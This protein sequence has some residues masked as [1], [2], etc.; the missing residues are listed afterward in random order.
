MTDIAQQTGAVAGE[1]HADWE[2]LVS[3][4]IPAYNHA[5][6][7]A[8]AVTSVLA[9]SYPHVELIVLDDGST[10]GTLGILEGFGQRFRWES[11][12]N[13]GQAATLAK[14]WAMARGEI[15]GYLS[16]DDVLLTDAVSAS[17][18][19][20]AAHP[21]ASAVYCDFRLIDPASKPVRE[22]HTPEF[23]LVRMAVELECPPGP[24]ALF[25][26][27]AYATAGPWN[28]AL[29]QMPDYDFWLRMALVGPLVRVPRVLAGFRVHEGSQTFG[30]VAAARAAEPVS[31]VSHFFES[32]GVPASVRALRGRALAN[33]AL[34]SAQLHVRSGRIGAGFRSAMSAFGR[35]P[36]LLV[37][38]RTWR[39]LF[40]AIFN[41]IGHRILWWLRGKGR[42]HG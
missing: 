41:R 34:V 24:G 8:E 22:V 28:P 13:M 6:Y 3:I 21:R 2:P 14:G 17:L 7:L 20:L 37:S 39:I 19:V 23:D 42:S 38:P 15:L 32:A 9:Q 31:I 4:V 27:R 40:N 18:R 29:R 10:D 11:H 30:A 35:E 33:A 12:P 36:P 1:S 5:E 26:R 16:A 25:R